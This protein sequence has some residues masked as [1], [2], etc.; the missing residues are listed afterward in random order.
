MQIAQ[1]LAGYSLGEADLLR[2][3]MGKKIRAEMDKQRARFV[4]GATERGVAKAQAEAIFDLLAKFADY[5][6]NKSHAA[7]YALV[8]YQTAYLKANFPVEFLAASMTL[9]MSNTDKLAEFRAEAERLGIRIVPP[10]VNRSG[11]EFEPDGKSIVYALAAIKGVGRQAVDSLAQARGSSPFRDL[12][13]L[14]DRIDPKA[15]NKRA[16]ECLAAAGAFDRLEPSRARA[17]AAADVV[18]SHAARR[19]GDRMA[20]QSQLFGG[21]AAAPLAVPVVPDWLPSDRLKREF[22]AI[23]F[24][25]SGHPLDDYAS[26]L[27]RLRVQPWVRFC[28]AVKE[29]GASAGR[30]AAIVVGR[31][32]KRTKTGNKMGI[33]A[34]SDP[35]APFEAVI[36]SEGL[37]QYGGLL[38]EG[39]RVVLQVSA[40][41]QGEDVRAR[42]QTVEALDELAARHQR[43][44]NV[45][46]RGA[47]PLDSLA[48]RLEAG[49]DGEVSL[50]LMLED[51]RSEVELRLPGRYRV[52]PQ[53]AG[54]IKAI[55]GVVMVEDL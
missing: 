28:E 48:R 5:G 34:L 24:F 35:S 50:V 42:I 19:L 55:P 4:D 30:L 26:T 40:E 15:V 51:T 44:L 27:K 21:A 10:D 6:F 53:I 8:A 54:A 25:L 3:A 41:L 13:D 29:E 22:D 33:L 39:A 49:G 31:T 2:R 37:Q 38:E 18:L 23:G 17:L 47:A 11:A 43:G 14:A 12:H 52:T 45:F 36:F 16:F 9:D 46:V 20:G 32:E 1:I 7:A